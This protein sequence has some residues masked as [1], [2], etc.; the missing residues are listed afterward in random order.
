[1]SIDNFEFVRQLGVGK[2]STVFMVRDKKTGAMASLKCIKKEHVH[3]ENMLGQLIREVKIGSFC[4]HPNIITLYGIFDDSES[5]YLLSELGCDGQLYNKLKRV[6]NFS[7]EA[8][9]F[10]VRQVLEA[11]TYLHEHSIYHRDIKPENIVL[12][13][14]RTTHYLGNRQVVRL[15]MVS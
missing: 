11:V 15:W 5:F 9:A 12:S 13:H 1:M 8:T 6:G 14:V 3:R 4:R 10:I 2:S 7:E